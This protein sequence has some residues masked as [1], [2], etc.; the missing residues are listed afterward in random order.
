MNRKKVLEKILKCLRLAK[1]S[2]EHEAAAAMRQA[3]KLMAAH[4]LT[5]GD[6]LAAEVNEASARSGATRRPVMWET[7]LAR[8]CADSFGCDVI[9][10]LGLAASGIPGQYSFIGCGASAEVCQFAFV[11]LLRQLRR[12][13]ATYIAANLARCK[14]RTRTR[15]ADEFCM[16]WLYAVK[17]TVQKFAWTVER[18]EAIAAYQRVNGQH[19]LKTIKGVDRTSK[20][21]SFKDGVAGAAAG[22]GIRLDRP[23]GAETREA[24]T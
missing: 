24:L 14:P 2:N 1:S 10:N 6:L 9:F 16:G 20:K 3:Q 22:R 13:R 15:R 23:V 18:R 11:V 4:D 17:S 7:A 5:E 21:S 19:E 12:A 8:I